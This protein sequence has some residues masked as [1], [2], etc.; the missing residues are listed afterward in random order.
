MSQQL[1]MST[2]A[3]V[4][5]SSIKMKVAREI[6]T[7][8]LFNH[9]YLVMDMFRIVFPASGLTVRG[10]GDWEQRAGQAERKGGR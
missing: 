2:W 9:L 1:V 4:L 8:T 7:L 10:G 3:S 5:V 6:L